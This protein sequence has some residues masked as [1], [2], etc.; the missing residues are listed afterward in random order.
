MSLY[1]TLST[2]FEA[3]VL[4]SALVLNIISFSHAY[5]LYPRATFHDRIA[6]HH[7]H[8]RAFKKRQTVVEAKYTQRGWRFLQDVPTCDEVDAAGLGSSNAAAMPVRKQPQ[9]KEWRYVDDRSIA[10]TFSTG[11]RWIGDKDSWIVP[12]DVAGVHIPS[13]T[14]NTCS[15]AICIRS[16][17]IPRW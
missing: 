3:D 7:L 9:Y 16:Q 5:S 2:S 11:P 15:Q 6:L 14:D 1:S 17:H 12:L 10:R 4:I 13:R 8:T